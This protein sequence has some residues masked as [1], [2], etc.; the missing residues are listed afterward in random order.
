MIDI[1]HLGAAPDAIETDFV[2]RG[3]KR[4]LTGAK[5][6]VGRAYKTRA[7]LEQQ[8]KACRREIARIST[9]S[10][11]IRVLPG[12]CEPQGG[13]RWSAVGEQERSKKFASDVKTGIGSGN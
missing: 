13:N 11:L 12:N 10:T 1:G 9:T 5:A 4:R 7:D 8:L 6:R 2:T 3:R